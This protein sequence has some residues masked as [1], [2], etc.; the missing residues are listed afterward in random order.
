VAHESMKRISRE[1]WTAYAAVAWCAVFGAFH[2]YWALGGTAGFAGFSMPSNRMLA[3]TRAPVYIRITWAVA[4]MCFVGAIVALAPTQP[5]S[6]RIPKWILLTPLWVAS[7]MLLVRGIGNPIQTA[8]IASGILTF[9]P[10]AG[11]LAQEWK[12]WLLLDLLAFSPWF[13]IGGLVFGATAWRLGRR[14]G[15]SSN[16]ETKPPNNSMEPTRPAAANRDRDTL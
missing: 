4:V 6:R 10:L 7:G 15:Q 8:L 16:S 5:W 13:V 14:R 1:R 12:Q 9:A 3:L 2:L 11:P